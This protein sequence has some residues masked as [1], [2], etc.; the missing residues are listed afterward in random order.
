MS[1]AASREIKWITNAPAS[2]V[3]VTMAPPD[4]PRHTRAMYFTG[5]AIK[6]T[7]KGV[8]M[9]L[10]DDHNEDRG[11]AWPAVGSLAK[12][13]GISEKQCR[14]VLQQLEKLGI[15]EK[16]PQLRDRS[17]A[18]TSNEYRFWFDRPFNKSETR[19]TVQRLKLQAQRTAAK[20]QQLP[21]QPPPTGGR[22][23]AENPLPR[24]GGGDSHGREGAPPTG[25]SPRTLKEHLLE[26]SRPEVCANATPDPVAKATWKRM[27]AEIQATVGKQSFDTW[28][29]PTRGL[30]AEGRVLVVRVPSANFA[31]IG[32]RFQNEIDAALTAVDDALDSVR[33]EV[34][35]SDPPDD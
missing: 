28:L 19:R 26:L 22:G 24:M 16:R 29:R 8:L 7:Q 31:H 32:K 17:E 13:V 1:H 5:P 10:A 6:P 12:R 20:P 25:G 34:A 15:I 23:A 30:R 4:D 14:R 11:F 9:Q 35:G 2:E 33:F 27:L 18:H 21:L 3:E